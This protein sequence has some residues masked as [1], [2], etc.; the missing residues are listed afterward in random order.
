MTLRSIGS[1]PHLILSAAAVVQLVVRIGSVCCD[2]LRMAAYF[3][4]WV[5][6]CCLCLSFCRYIIGLIYD[7][8]YR[9]SIMSCSDP[10][11][12]RLCDLR[13]DVA[14]E[15]SQRWRTFAANAA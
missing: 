15:G 5:V 12:T 10:F 1:A 7:V 14:S 9:T 8:V 6:E 13:L 4:Q 2:Y 3:R 11:T